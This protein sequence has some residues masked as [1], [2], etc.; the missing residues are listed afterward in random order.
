[1]MFLYA[2]KLTIIG[3]IIKNLLSVLEA[4]CKSAYFDVLD[5]G[6]INSASSYDY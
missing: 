1:M 3:Q 4:F 2:Y 5:V 6:G